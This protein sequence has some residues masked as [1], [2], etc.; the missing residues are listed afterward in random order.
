MRSLPCFIPS[1][2]TS[3]LQQIP[4]LPHVR[5]TLS[6]IGLMGTGCAGLL[7]THRAY[8]HDHVSLGWALVPLAASIIVGGRRPRAFGMMMYLFWPIALASMG[9]IGTGL[10]ALVVGTGA[11]LVMIASGALA[12]FMGITGCTLVF[13][14]I[15]VFPASPL[16]P[17][18]AMLGALPDPIFV[19]IMCV[20]GTAIIEMS[21]VLWSW[22]MRSL[23][24][25][26][27]VTAPV[28][29]AILSDTPPTPSQQ[30]IAP[31]HHPPGAWTEHPMPLGITERGRW[32]LLRDQLPEG[33]TV[34]LGEN[35]FDRDHADAL[36]FWCRTVSQ[37]QLTLF[38]G[39]SVPWQTIQR[40]AVWKLTAE[41]CRDDVSRNAVI[42][43]HDAQ[44]LSATFGIPGL[45][46]TWG[47]MPV[48]PRSHPSR[49]MRPE[50]VLI[51]LEAFLPWAWLNGPLAFFWDGS[52]PP[53]SDQPIIILSND[54]AFGPYADSVRTLRRK[55]AASLAL[56]TATPQSPARLV[57]HAETDRSLILLTR[58]PS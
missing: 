29:A 17:L 24:L 54:H 27:T 13:L 48:T 49:F 37:R 28:S 15:P 33:S 43:R 58:H 51:C 9:F 46:G 35:V 8:F 1:I 22:W 42:D 41:T 32:L 5:T 16:L 18:T 19:M 34:I 57:L 36:S 45:T 40:S 3:A 12:A 25:S 21:G 10:P 30:D 39:V 31:R 44:V 23:L 50:T 14:L 56:Y 47:P 2:Q 55:V 11:L 6:V 26:L 7:I 53:P 20:L 4:T 38:V 52:P